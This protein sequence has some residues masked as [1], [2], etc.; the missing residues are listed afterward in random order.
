MSFWSSPHTHQF[1][2]STTATLS[3]LIQ[4]QIFYPLLWCFLPVRCTHLWLLDIF[5]VHV[6]LRR[7]QRKEQKIMWRRMV[8]VCIAPK[9]ERYTLSQ[10]KWITL[11]CSALLSYYSNWIQLCE[12]KKT[13]D[14]PFTLIGP[15]EYGQIIFWECKWPIATDLRTSEVLLM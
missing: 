10:I 12:F 11:I 9:I 13:L 15:F 6:K 2:V 8:T 3:T 14:L 1:K 5:F 7:H 4:T